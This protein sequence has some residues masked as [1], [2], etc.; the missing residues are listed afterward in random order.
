MSMVQG[1]FC[2]NSKS[3]NDTLFTV[4]VLNYSL[5]CAP[6][7]QLYAPL[8]VPK[9]AIISVAS[10]SGIDTRII[11]YNVPVPALSWPNL[12]SFTNDV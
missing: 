12:N 8:M 11:L 10:A 1:V 5:R 6:N 7:N 9:N 4:S 3:P 2:D